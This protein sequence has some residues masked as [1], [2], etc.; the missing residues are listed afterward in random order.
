MPPLVLTG[1][2]LKQIILKSG[3]DSY[4]H[5]NIIFGRGST[6]IHILKMSPTGIYN[7]PFFVSRC[8]D[9]VFFTII[10]LGL[11]DSIHNKIISD[12]KVWG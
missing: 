7:K 8:K 3:G 12:M 11:D 10:T 2:N 4:H 1:G 9:R 5:Y 6:R